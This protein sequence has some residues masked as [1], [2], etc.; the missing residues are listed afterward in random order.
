MSRSLFIVLWRQREDLIEVFKILNLSDTILSYPVLSNARTRGHKFCKLFKIELEKTF[1]FANRVASM[2]NKLPG[3]VV[4]APT[5]SIFK[6][7][8]VLKQDTT[9]YGH[10]ERPMA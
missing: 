10:C 2:W 3:E 7:I 1:L 5:V 6:A 8:V 9:L 4:Q